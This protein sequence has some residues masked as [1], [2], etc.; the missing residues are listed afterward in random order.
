MHLILLMPTT[1][2]TPTSK[3]ALESDPMSLLLAKLGTK[4]I[5]GPE[6]IKHFSCSTQP[7]MKFSL[8]INMKMLTKGSI[9]I[10]SEKFSCSAMFSKKEFAI[11]SNLRFSSMMNFMLSSGP[12]MKSSNYSDM[13]L[14]TR[15]NANVNEWM[16][17]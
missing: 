13:D 7:S 8:L 10:L 17:G 4:C 3:T 2:T 11:V 5:P 12:G 14:N 6:I 9:F 1:I 15:V 16:D